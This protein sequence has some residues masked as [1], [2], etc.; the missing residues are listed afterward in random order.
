ME[1]RKMNKLDIALDKLY[2]I[3]FDIEGQNIL[4]QFI[5]TTPV[6][7][8][9]LKAFREELPKELYKT[10]RTNVHY[11]F[12]I[13]QAI[14]I[15]KILID[16]KLFP[17]VKLVTPEEIAN[18]KIDLSNKTRIIEVMKALKDLPLEYELIERPYIFTDNDNY[19][20]ID[21]K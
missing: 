12:N 9:Q 4:F 17:I 8:C 1:Y 14:L 20:F 21:E 5:N 7:P 10:F 19:I 2:T 18:T 16:M 13:T 11:Y 6:L 15:Q 3:T